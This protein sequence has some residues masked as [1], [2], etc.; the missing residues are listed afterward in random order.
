MPAWQPAWLSPRHP[1]S[2]ARRQPHLPQTAAGGGGGLNGV[3]GGGKGIASGGNGGSSSSP[4]GGGSGGLWGSYLKALETSPVSSRGG[5]A[6]GQAAAW[7]LLHPCASWC[8][9][10]SAGH[11]AAML[12]CRWLASSSAPWYLHPQ[13]PHAHAPLGCMAAASL[14]HTR[15]HP[16][17]CHAPPHT[18]NAPPDPDQGPHQRLHQ[19]ARQPVRP[20]G[21]GR[22]RAAGLE[23]AGDLH[24]H[25]RRICGAHAAL[26]VLSAQQAGAR[27]HHCRCSGWRQI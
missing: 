22:C 12:P 6:K 14:P 26:L 21:G 15:A 5:G 13:K 25:W 11:R 7:L 1:S 19:H 20:A 17:P 3:G 27:S 16:P 8:G 2:G 10:L 4:Q 9:T 24:R 23:A 18:H